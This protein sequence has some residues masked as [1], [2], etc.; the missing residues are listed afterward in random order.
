LFFLKMK[1]IFLQAL[2]FILL[3]ILL[4]IKEG[5]A[6]IGFP[7]PA[8]PRTVQLFEPEESAFTIFYKDSTLFKVSPP[9]FKRIVT[10]DSSGKFVSVTEAVD[11]TEYYLPAVVDL[12]T[13]VSMRINFDNR[14]LL[15]KSFMETIGKQV[16]RQ[17]GALELEIPIRIRSK[18]FRR[19]FGSDRVALRVTGNISFDLSGRTEKR[20]GMAINAIQN[21]GTF[22]PR[23]NQTQQ[24]T[25]EGKIGDKVTVSVEQNSEATFD[26]ENTLKLTYEGDEDEIVQRIEAG[27]IGL[28]LPST[29][30]VIFGGSNQGLF[31][32]KSHLKVG[33]WNITSIASL[34][35][36]E[37]EKLTISGSSTTSEEIIRD[38]EFISNQ[39]FF[40]DDYYRDTF[41]VFFG[42]DMTPAIPD[43]NKVIKNLEVYVTNNYSDVDVRFGIAY[44]DKS[45]LQA[46]Q[47]LKLSPDKLQDINTSS[48]EI[49]S[50]NFKRL[51]EGVDFIYDSDRG[52]FW[53]MQLVDNDDI[54]AVAYQ[55][56]DGGK[57]G[58]LTEEITSSQDSLGYVLRLIKPANMLSDAPTWSLMMRN[59]YSMRGSQIE[60]D[61]FDLSIEY[62]VNSEHEQIQQEEPR[63]S[64]L[65]LLGL[66]RQDENGAFIEGG[67]KKVD[68]NGEILNLERGIIIFP[69]LQPFDPVVDDNPAPPDNTS[70]YQI[71]DNYRVKIYNTTNRTEKINE[72]KF[73]ILVTSRSRRSTFDLGWNVLEGSEEVLLNGDPLRRDIDYSIDYL[74][75]QL[76]LI[77][78]EAMRSSANL[79]IKYERATIFQLDKKTLLGTRAEYRFWEDS[80][81]GFTA[82]YMNKSTL[83]QRVRIGQ[84]P[85]RNFI[86]DINTA[87]NFKPRFLTKALDALP[88]IETDAPSSFKVEAEFAQVLPDPNTMNNKSTGDN[89]GVAYID[90]FE[91]SKRM[92]TL[93][94]RYNTWTPASPPQKYYVYRDFTP[95]DTIKV[96]N[97]TIADTTVDRNR[98]FLEWYNPYNRVLIKDIWPERDLTSRTEQTTDV[99]TLK[100]RRRKDQNQDSAWVGIM[101]STAMFADQQKSKFLEIWIKGNTKSSLRINID[102]GQISEDWNLRCYNE[103]QGIIYGNDGE[104]GRRRAD[105]E[106][107]NTN[108]LLD[109]G[110]DTGL[111]GYPD[112]HPGDIGNLGKEWN[113]NWKQPDQDRDDYSGVN[114]TEGNSQARGQIY[115]DTE[116]LDGDGRLDLQ[117]TYYTYSFTLSDDDEISRKYR[118]SETKYREG[119][120]ANQKTGWIQ[121]RIPLKEFILNAGNSDSTFEQVN[122]VRLWLSDID[123]LQQSLSIAAFDFVGNEWE[124]QGIADVDIESTNYV[125]NDSI[126]KI[127]VYNTEENRYTKDNMPLYNSPPGVTGI[128]DRITEA[129]SKEQSL[130]LSFNNLPGQSKAVA[131]K[132]MYETLSL[133]NYQR[134]KMFVHGPMKEAGNSD[135]I[136]VALRFGSD[137]N[138]YY[139]IEKYVHPG[140]DDRN[141]FDLDLDQ[142]AKIKEERFYDPLKKIYKKDGTMVKGKASLGTIRYFEVVVY[143]RDNNTFSGE[144]WL[145]ELRVSDA[146][147]E[148]G[149]ALRLKTNLQVADLVTV[150]A[151]WESRD[152]D[153]HDLKTQFG[154]GSTTEIQNYSGRIQIDKLLPSGLNLS[155]PVD[156]RVS[157]DR[158]IPKYRPSTDILSGY[159]NNTI[160]KKV[161]SLFGMREIS[162]DLDTI[163]SKSEVYGIGMTVGTL[164]RSPAWYLYYTIDQLK[165]DFD[166]SFRTSSD[167]RTRKSEATQYRE[168]VSYSIPFGRNNYIEPFKMFEDKPILKKLS[169]QKIYYTPSNLSA[170]L[171]INDSKT[172]NQLRGE[173]SVTVVP[174]INSTRS[175]NGSYR[176]LPSVDFSYSRTHQADADYDRENYTNMRLIKDIITRGD[177]GKDTDI[178]QS[179]KMDYSPKLVDWLTT[180]YSYST[181]FKFFYQN[182]DKGYKQSATSLTRSLSTNFYPSKLISLI[183]KPKT[184]S[185]TGRRRARVAPSEKSKEKEDKDEKDEQK[186]TEDKKTKKQV[187]L[188]N[189]L[190]WFYALFNNWNNINVNY[191]L[192]DNV[193][194]PYVQ[195]IPGWRYQFGLTKSTAQL[196]TGVVSGFSYIPGPTRSYGKSI[197]TST[198]YKISKN[199]STSFSHDYSESKTIND[200]TQ[201]GD[202]S[203]TYYISGDD[204]TRGGKFDYKKLFKDIRSFIPDWQ[205]NITGLETFLFFPEFAKSVSLRHGRSSKYNTSLRLIEVPPDSGETMPR[206]ELLPD[207]ETFTNNYQPF[208][209]LRI[210]WKIGVSSTIRIN[211]SS[212]FDFRRGGGETKTLSNTFYI[213][214]SY[215]TSGGFRI[216]I[217]IWP[218]K[219]KVI[220]N[221]IDFSLT[222][223][224][225]KNTT[226][227]KQFDQNEF[228]ETQKTSSWK[229]RPSAS[230]RFSKRI[231]GSIFYEK[232]VN[233]T[234]ISG[235]YSYNEFGVTVNIAIRD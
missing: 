52:F 50:G 121:Y 224:K 8:P 231:S 85:F 41:E 37:Q 228:N 233:E 28:S 149:S 198:Q 11:K 48:G 135:S 161:Q 117:N 104:H 96:D 94:I 92:T 126:F 223:D 197:S 33:N 177:F 42:E 72:T 220:K 55:T 53:L 114:G 106:D 189:P 208:I 118:I 210:E 1:K 207:N 20:S 87:L 131:K 116:D 6:Q 230:Y 137:M 19:I 71:A 88:F 40:I 215:R 113:D 160:E 139:E 209:E 128:R 143:N 155:L 61:G 102:V 122:Y 181:N 109:E 57:V 146:R 2:S 140:W 4:G 39:Y 185:S 164:T 49:E 34:E 56:K 167:Y 173:D 101:R 172:A 95:Y 206:E 105:T 190:L 91:S 163:V 180:S 150:N 225:S 226:Y 36:G 62:N 136:Y 70:K 24:F 168:T 162:A 144:M 44:A 186:Q 169:D 159:Q 134:L 219:N 22:S 157:F 216:P 156:A 51:E 14:Q 141:K 184:S 10:L 25:I 222:F 202:K 78:P 21:R 63:K 27:N 166:Y 183:Y 124:E 133:V 194:T 38:Y 176:M 45:E 13:Y 138:N 192:T 129:M 234:K 147:Q 80:F 201:T 115:P 107:K 23:F 54:L 30:Y 193:T 99:L 17:I 66:D 60:R 111:D 123:T 232:G 211:K 89:N 16:E 9:F 82:L 120:K 76:T 205:L 125:K 93:G 12:D 154:S 142:L 188:P 67:D 65:Y 79:E 73:E 171:T 75:G 31:G 90:D 182:L 26:F 217:P 77:S 132:I 151:E 69:G 81:F 165:L 200:K 175:I 68:L 97:V 5:Y 110:E 227:Q 170:N 47:N 83:D 59:V 3:F 74:T 108:G 199:I 187:K 145:D 148:S 153:F 18:T 100:A 204:P 195:N 221:E 84:E 158:K 103:Q 7:L 46:M 32:L 35:R 179:F 112:G 203:I 127:M 152:A 191:R 58:T 229:L 86:W 64:F 119:P 43:E 212:K 178:G 174:N 235:E 196:D 213:E 130:V 218:F 98:G 29:K 15:M 214:A